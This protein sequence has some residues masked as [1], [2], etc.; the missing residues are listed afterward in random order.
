MVR[1]NNSK[2]DVFGQYH[3]SDCKYYVLMVLAD[4]STDDAISRYHICD[5]KDYAL[6][7]PADP[8]IVKMVQSAGTTSVITN[9]MFIWYRPTIVNIK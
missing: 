1:A 4:H 3:I 2:V 5:Y 9:T 7:V 8:T 6:V